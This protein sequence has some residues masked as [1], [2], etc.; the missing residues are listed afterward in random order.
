MVPFAFVQ[1]SIGMN[2]IRLVNCHIDADSYNGYIHTDI[3]V[4]V[5]EY[6]GKVGEGSER[7]FTVVVARR[8]R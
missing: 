8:V 5:G 1:I 4:C 2:R 6:L 3:C 7:I